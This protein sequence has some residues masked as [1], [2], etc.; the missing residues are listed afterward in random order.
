MLEL[1]EKNVDSFSPMTFSELRKENKALKEQ[2]KD[3]D[4]LE[5]QNLNL[6]KELAELK[7][8]WYFKLAMLFP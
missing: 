8:K 1:N 6:N 2:L 3:I 4:D 7:N 5:R